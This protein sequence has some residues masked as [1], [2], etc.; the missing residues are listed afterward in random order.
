MSMRCESRRAERN[1]SVSPLGAPLTRCD[2][3]TRLPG[4]ETNAVAHRSSIDSCRSRKKSA[5]GPWIASMQSGGMNVLRICGPGIFLGVFSQ[6]G[7]LGGLRL[8]DVGGVC[9]ERGGMTPLAAVGLVSR[10]SACDGH[11]PPRSTRA[12]AEGAGWAPL[13]GAGRRGRADGIGGARPSRLDALTAV[14]A[15]SAAVWFSGRAWRHVLACIE[16]QGARHGR[17]ALYVELGHLL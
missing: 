7:W 14:G 15:W 12:G 13:L 3:E 10:I 11:P 8:R 1:N 5:D 2:Q 6:G 4:D 17:V 16:V 9:G